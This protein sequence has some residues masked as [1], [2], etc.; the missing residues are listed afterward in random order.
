MV[1]IFSPLILHF[2]YIL[3]NLGLNDFRYRILFI[4]FTKLMLI[5]YGVNPVVV[6]HIIESLDY[7]ID[8]YIE[9]QNI[10]QNFNEE[11]NLREIQWIF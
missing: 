5:L 11:F 8:D 10:I 4:K 1:E 7:A 2:S 6:D 3:F 9:K